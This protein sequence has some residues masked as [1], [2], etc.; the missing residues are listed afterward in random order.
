MNGYFLKQML[1]KNVFDAYFVDEKN[2]EVALY[3][4]S[5]FFYHLQL[6]KHTMLFL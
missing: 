2:L 1:E 5:T 6:S 4:K 3:L